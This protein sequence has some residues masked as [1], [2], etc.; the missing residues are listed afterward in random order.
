MS[1]DGPVRIVRWLLAIYPPKFRARYGAD[2]AQQFAETWRDTSGIGR[3]LLF[4]LRTIVDLSVAGLA[5]RRVARRIA[6][7]QVA[8]ARRLTPERF[9]YVRFPSGHRYALRLLR[10]QPGFALFLTLTPSVS[11]RTLPCSAW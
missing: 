10:R 1:G 6:E 3:R 4:V 5:E 2:M 7:Q 9:S 11:V 8:P